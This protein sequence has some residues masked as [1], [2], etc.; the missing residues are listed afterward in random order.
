MRVMHG[1]RSSA[2]R[3]QILATGQYTAQQRIRKQEPRKPGEI[4]E[5][6]IPAAA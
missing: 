3:N 6:T 5:R 2:L 4:S 1:M